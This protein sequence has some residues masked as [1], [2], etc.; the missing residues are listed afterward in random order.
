MAAANIGARN[1]KKDH[2]NSLRKARVDKNTIAFRE[3]K[4]QQGCAVCGETFGPCLEMHHSNPDKEH[5]VANLASY[6]LQKMLTEAL[7]CVVL[8]SNCHRKVHHGVVKIQEGVDH[9]R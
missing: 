7:K 3:W 9:D 4:E 5:N 2:Y 8:C 6:S 1:K